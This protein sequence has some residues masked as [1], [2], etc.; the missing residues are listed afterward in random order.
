MNDSQ[1]SYLKTSLSSC[2]KKSHISGLCEMLAFF[3]A[4]FCSAM[5]VTAVV[6][7]CSIFHLLDRKSRAIFLGSWPIIDDLTFEKQ[8]DLGIKT[9]Q[10][11]YG[12]YK[13]DWWIDEKLFQLERRAIFSKVG[14]KT[15]MLK[16]TNLLR[17]GCM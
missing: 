9:G 4:S 14:A 3:D 2:A 5:L 11:Q 7:L 12:I 8:K 1:I 17:H 13:R 16:L 10:S 6:V 15:Y